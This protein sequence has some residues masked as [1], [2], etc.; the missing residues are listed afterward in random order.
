MQRDPFLQV[1]ELHCAADFGQDGK[2]VRIPLDHHL[3]ELDLISFV[4]FDLGAVHYRVVFPLPALLVDNSDR[5]LAVHDHQIAGFG[6]HRLNINEPDR[7]G[8]FRVQPR[9]LGNSR[10]CTADMEGTHR[11]LRSRFADRLCCDHA[12]GFSQLNQA[13]G[14]Q[15]ASVAHH[16]DAAFRFAGKH[17]ANLHPFNAGC[18]NRASQLFRDLLV[19]VHHDV[20]VVVLNFLERH[21]A[22]DAVAKR[23]DNLA[24]FHDTG[25]VDSIYRSAIVFADDDVLC[26]VN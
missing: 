1:F 20:T 26:H 4:D 9:L 2:G 7:T 21:A 22:D 8:V 16:A 6:F 25:D 23:L 3:P 14:S 18:L 13:S 10:C 11:E 19:D 17:R 5:T 12:S 24:R 15:V